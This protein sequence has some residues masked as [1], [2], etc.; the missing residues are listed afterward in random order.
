MNTLKISPTTAKD[1]GNYIV[2]ATNKF[3]EA[4]AFAR[5][6]VK[7]LGD[8]PLKEELIRKEEKQL[9]PIFKEKIQDQIVT[10]D[11]EVKFECVVTGKPYPKVCIIFFWF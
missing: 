5:L 9:A 3:G 10:E 4:K 1:K 2:K 11:D 8:F 7:V 6:V